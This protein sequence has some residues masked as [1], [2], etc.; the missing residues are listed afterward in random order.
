MRGPE[1]GSNDGGNTE[2]G[3]LS[4]LSDW[5]DVPPPPAPSPPKVPEGAPLSQTYR[6]VR[7]QNEARPTP[8]FQPTGKRGTP[9]RK[10]HCNQATCYIGAQMNAPMG[11]LADLHGVPFMANEQAVRLDQ[12][13]SGYREV[14]AEEAQKLAD[15]G[16]AVLA[17]QPHTGHGH[18]ATVRPDNTY[19]APYEDTN[20]GGSGP[21]INQIG[22][23]VGIM[24]ASKAFR[25]MPR[26]RYYAPE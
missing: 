24:H 7:A 23:S 16:I 8:R 9:S 22:G 1:K 15:S 20:P 3:F 14:P 18:I 12:P 6:L 21:M 25:S 2:R 5:F 17:V 13:N 4:G 26:P 11:A 10:T 19:M